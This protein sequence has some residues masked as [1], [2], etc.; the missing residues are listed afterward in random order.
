MGVN[1]TSSQVRRLGF[2]SQHCHLPSYH[3]LTTYHPTS[4][5]NFKDWMSYVAQASWPDLG[6]CDLQRPVSQPALFTLL[7]FCTC[8][9][10]SGGIGKDQLSASLTPNFMPRL[11]LQQQLVCRFPIRMWGPWTRASVLLTCLSHLCRS[12]LAHSRC[13]LN[14]DWSISWIRW[15]TPDCVPWPVIS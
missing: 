8:S 5:G 6:G 9:L 15:L 10:S 4:C 14:A 11:K 12:G 1:D 2:K 3:P 7:G 13:L